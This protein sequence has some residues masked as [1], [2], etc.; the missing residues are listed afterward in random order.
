MCQNGSAPQIN[1]AVAEVKEHI[2]EADELL[3]EMQKANGTHF[4]HSWLQ[5]I[6]VHLFSDKLDVEAPCNRDMRLTNFV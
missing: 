5:N 4:H 6:L 3:E 1:A 2:A